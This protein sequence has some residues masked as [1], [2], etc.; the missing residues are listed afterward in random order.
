MVVGRG[1]GD[2]TQNIIGKGIMP[3]VVHASTQRWGQQ[4]GDAVE[5][6]VTAVSVCVC[7]YV[8]MCVCK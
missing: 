6:T 3:S 5:R 1:L 7:V 8:C 2:A 4:A